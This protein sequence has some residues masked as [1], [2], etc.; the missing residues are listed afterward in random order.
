MI[1]VLTTIYTAW[2]YAGGSAGIGLQIAK[3]LAREGCDITIID[4]N[5][6]KAAVSDIET[7]S[8]SGKVQGLKGDVADYKQA[9]APGGL[10]IPVS[11]QQAA[12]GSQVQIT[13]SQTPY[14]FFGGNAGSSSNVLCKFSRCHHM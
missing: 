12:K 2:G 1:R 3:D 14:F 6:T 13:T 5:E 4:V 10:P 8:R 9:S 7:V 11:F